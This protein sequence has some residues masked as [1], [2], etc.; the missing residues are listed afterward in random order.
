M[1]PERMEIAKKLRFFFSTIYAQTK[2]D[3]RVGLTDLAKSHEKSLLPI[4]NRVFDTK[5]IDM[6]EVCA[7]YPAIDYGDSENG[8]S[9]QMSVTVT[10]KKVK[11]TIDKFLNHK[12]DEVFKELWMFFIYVEAI[13]KGVFVSSEK[14][15]VQYLTLDNIIERRRIQT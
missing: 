9:L 14:V 15:K 1:Q 2:L 4:I 3:A 5:F 6:N 10:K 7:N 11:D 12:Q 8:L 13:P